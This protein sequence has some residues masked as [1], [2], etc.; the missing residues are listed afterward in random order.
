MNKAIQ[1][2]SFALLLTMFSLS[3][4]RADMAVGPEVFVVPVVFGGIVIGVIA[5]IAW[6]I[7][8]KI[9]KKNASKSNK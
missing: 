1:T 9:K 2:V 5:L 8:R 3:M 7:I 6:L 4:V